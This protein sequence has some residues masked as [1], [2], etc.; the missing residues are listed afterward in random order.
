MS[1]S[2]IIE[3][4]ELGRHYV[5]GGQTIAALDGVSFEIGA[6]EWVAIV[7][8]SGSGKSTLMSVLGC[9]DRPTSG[10]YR[11][12]GR[13]V[14]ELSDDDLSSVRNQH[15]GFVFQSFQLLPRV[16]ALRNVELP[17]VYRGV[18]RSRRRSMAAEALARVGLHDRMLHRPTELSGGQRQRVAIARALVGSPTVLLADEPSGNLDSTTE[19]EIMALFEALHDEGHTIVLVTHEPTVAA[20]CP[21]AIRLADGRVVDDGAGRQIAAAHDREAVSG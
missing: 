13:N 1:V 6:G 3:V 15:I 9:M 2:P 19:T 17:L 18:A 21:R 7:G 16:S 14:A 11:L 10:Q 8:R 5:M 20:R 4:V 12:D